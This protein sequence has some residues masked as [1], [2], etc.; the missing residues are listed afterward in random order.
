MSNFV[1]MHVVQTLPQP[2][3]LSIVASNLGL[4]A[5]KGNRFR[6]ISHLD[7]CPTGF[8]IKTGSIVVI[9]AYLSYELRDLCGD[10][11]D[12]IGGVPQEVLITVSIIL[13]FSMEY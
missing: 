6:M 8:P 12:S 11:K 3:A 5:P 7:V 1:K 2:T 9:I 4:S 10:D 13:S